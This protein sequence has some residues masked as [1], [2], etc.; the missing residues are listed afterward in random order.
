LTSSQPVEP[1]FQLSDDSRQLRF[2][3]HSPTRWWDS[4]RCH[5]PPGGDVSCCVQV[6]VRLVPTD[7]APEYRLA[8]AVLLG[9]VTTRVAGHGCVGGAD[10][11]D[12]SRSL[13]IQSQHEGT[14]GAAE[15]GSV[16]PGFLPHI[17]ARAINGSARGTGHLVDPEI[18]NPDQ[19]EPSCEVGARLFDPVLPSIP[20]SS[21][22]LR[23]CLLDLLT[24]V[25]AE[26]SSG[27]LALQSPQPSR[28]SRAQR[29][30]VRRRV[31]GGQ[32][33]RRCHPAVN[34][35][36]LVPAGARD[37]LRSHCEGDVP[38]SRPV[39]SH[40]IRLR[41]GHLPAP[42]KPNPAN[43]RDPYGPSSSVESADL[44]GF[45]GDDSEAFMA[46]TLS[47]SGPPMRA[48]E[49]VREGLREVSQSLLLH[50]L[51]TS[52]QPAEF[53]TSFGQLTTLF[54]KRRCRSTSGSPMLVL[55]DGQVPHEPRMR[56]VL[57]QRRLLRRRGLE[58]V[59]RHL[60]DARRGDRHIP[61]GRERRHL[62]AVIGEAAMPHTS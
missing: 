56:A 33:R 34:T 25:R 21:S 27:E 40:P 12:P 61:E 38:T 8:L 51:R 7:T 18:F 13:V 22:D 62:A 44:F 43:L 60:P 1:G 28:L 49:E 11:L 10:L 31:A 2:A 4:P 14:P 19:V 45:H 17:P 37:R 57:Q 3:V 54:G 50:H 16:Q 20:F 47:P 35:D 46:I 48:I 9:T 30:T 23:D 59:T 6:S 36:N 32:S 52:A 29:G 55:L 39:A 15:D 53:L 42:A 24:A 41:V 5:R 58:S 26:L